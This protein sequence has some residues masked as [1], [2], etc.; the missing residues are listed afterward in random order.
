MIL[1]NCAA[2][3]V[4]IV[5]SINLDYLDHRKAAW[6]HFVLFV[7]T[8]I[9]RS[10]S[11]VWTGQFSSVVIFKHCLCERIIG[12]WSFRGFVQCCYHSRTLQCARGPYQTLSSLQD[13]SVLQSFRTHL[14]FPFSLFLSLSFSHF[15]YH[16]TVS[17]MC[18][19]WCSSCFLSPGLLIGVTAFTGTLVY[20]VSVKEQRLNELRAFRWEPKTVS[21]P[22]S[23]VTND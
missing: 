16:Y 14:T 12:V 17:R 13:R 7:H 19:V 1:I 9:I 21:W 3:N 10:L 15:P 6:L 8:D 2:L 11:I 20:C 4:T 5:E 23:S 22:C 18:G